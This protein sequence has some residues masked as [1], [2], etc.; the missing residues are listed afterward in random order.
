[1]EESRHKSIVAGRILDILC[2]VCG[3]RSSGKHYG[4]YACDGCSGFF[5]RSI[6]KN[7]NYECK[8]P[9]KGRCAI[10]KIHRNQCR[11][12]RLQRCLGVS[13]RKD[14]VQNERGPRM[15]KMKRKTTDHE[16]YYCQDTDFIRHNPKI[17]RNE[18]LREELTTES[19]YL[20]SSSLQSDLHKKVNV[21]DTLTLL[22]DECWAK[23]D[24][25]RPGFFLIPSQR[26]TGG[27]DST[28]ASFTLLQQSSISLCEMA[29]RALFSTAKSIKTLLSHK[30]NEVIFN[31]IKWPSILLL[32]LGHN[33]TMTHFQ[34]VLGAA[35]FNA[36]DLFVKLANPINMDT[37]FEDYRLEV[38]SIHEASLR[39]HRVLTEVSKTKL[40]E[41][42]FDQLREYLLRGSK[43]FLREKKKNVSLC[44]G[45]STFTK[46]ETFYGRREL[47]CNLS[48]S[49][50]S[51]NPIDAEKVFF[52]KTIG[53]SNVA[54]ILTDILKDS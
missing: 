18:K 8:G 10:D 17:G 50:E 12:C 40:I 35:M 31:Q 16:Y 4:I 51:V 28:K 21:N 26:Q 2:E 3:D 24:I 39:I 33:C 1:M 13:M 20:R 42:E 19:L 34:E 23:S 32:E 22:S 14:A 48:R 54:Q 41:S 11:A 45:S 38:Q 6:R 47:L 29:A 15:S 9:E 25:S 27:Y 43:E 53:I 5:K 46:Q 36:S 52:R 37:D 30:E 49:L 44:C 7:R